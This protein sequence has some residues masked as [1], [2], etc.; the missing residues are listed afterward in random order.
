MKK[1]LFILAACTLIIIAAGLYYFAKDEPENAGSPVEQ[2]QK[3]A[4]AN[5]VFS[6]SSLAEER[7]G[8]KV[9]ELSAEKIEM[10]TNK[11]QVTLQN[12]KGTFYDEKGGHVEMIARTGL[13]DTETRN[14][15]LEGEVKGVSA[16]GAVFLAQVVRWTHQDGRILGSGGIKLTKDDTVITGDNIESDA[17]MDKVKVLGNARAIK[18]GSANEG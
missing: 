10:D 4:M 15:T 17:K 6:G 14:V 12:I 2:Q 1:S 18:G 5:L 11:K 8:K 3:S 7:D 13:V 9:W 16:D